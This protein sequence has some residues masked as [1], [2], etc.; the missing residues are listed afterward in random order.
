MLDSAKQGIE[1]VERLE[2]SD[3]EFVARMRE[4]LGA[5]YPNPFDDPLF[6]DGD[7]GPEARGE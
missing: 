4:V 2:R 5:H 3:A 7:D 6:F 1:A